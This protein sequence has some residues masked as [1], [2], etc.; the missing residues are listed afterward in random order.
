LAQIEKEATAVLGAIVL[1]AGESTRMGTAKAVLPDASGRPFVARLVRTFRAA[2]IDEVVVVTGASH[3]AVVTA[4]DGD[5]LRV[6]PRVARNSDPSRGQLSSLWAGLDALQHLPLE[7]VLMTPV[8]VP[9]VKEQTV[10]AVIDAWRERHS[11]IV[12]PVMGERHGHPVLFDRRVFAE[13]RGAPLA[14]GAKAV[15][16]GHEHQLLNVDVDDEGCLTD[17]DTPADYRA[18]LERGS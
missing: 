17:V 11:P 3:D 14:E 18:L 5:D 12:R 10:R 6:T 8:D 7:A 9:M 4:L 16:H 13:L 2:G 1:A 15:V